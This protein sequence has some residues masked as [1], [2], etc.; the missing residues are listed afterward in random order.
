M[1]ELYP[2]KTGKHYLHTAE[3]GAPSANVSGPRLPAV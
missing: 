1:A 2:V 3:V